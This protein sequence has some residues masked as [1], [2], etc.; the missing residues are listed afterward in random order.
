MFD[1]YYSS[2]TSSP[3]TVVGMSEAD[4]NQ[5]I[6]DATPSAPTYASTQAEVGLTGT[7]NSPTLMTDPGQVATGSTLDGALAKLG[8][9][10]NAITRTARQLGSAVGSV[11]RTIGAVPGQYQ[12]GLDAANTSNNVIRRSPGARAGD[13]W[14]G[15][16][17]GERL[18]LGIAAVA[19]L[20]QVF[21][22][23]K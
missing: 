15:A 18:A 6:S 13:L 7:A 14:A 10:G 12:A 16:S 11:N 19:L 2:D 22:A 17:P 4:F 1:D 21:G 8:S 3:D 9:I 23:K 20:Y 5:A